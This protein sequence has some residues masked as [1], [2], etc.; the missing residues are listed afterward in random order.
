MNDYFY[1]TNINNFF[2]AVQLHEINGSVIIMDPYNGDIVSM[3]GGINYNISNFNRV[4]Q[5]YRQPGSSI[6]PFIYAKALETK[7]FLPNTKILDSSIL[8][9][10]GSNL[11][12]WI[13]KN[14]SN[15]SYGELTFRRALETSNNLVTLKIGLDL[16]L[17]SVNEFLNKI[18]FYN[19]TNTTDVYA[20]L[21]G[22][23]K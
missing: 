20:T 21:L 3:V 7:K 18:N 4:T 5:A 14:Y 22:A 2:Y 19:N 11:P 6:K 16:G 8:L 23:R 12:V 17:N 9:D 10:Q 15:K 13:P 1:V